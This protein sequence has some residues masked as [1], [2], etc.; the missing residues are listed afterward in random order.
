M[1]RAATGQPNAEGLTSPVKWVDPVPPGPLPSYPAIKV[2]SVPYEP[3]DSPEAK[4]VPCAGVKQ[5]SSFNLPGGR[6]YQSCQRAAGSAR[7]HAD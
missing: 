4:S 7:E 3:R 6:H 1:P 5:W 2:I